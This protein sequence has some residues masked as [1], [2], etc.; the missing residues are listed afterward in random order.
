MINIKQS[1]GNCLECPSSR[2]NSILPFSNNPGNII[3]TQV[4][5]LISKPLTDDIIKNNFFSNNQYKKFFDLIK[6]YNLDQLNYMISSISL[7]QITVS[8]DD[9]ANID[10]IYK[11]CLNNTKH[12]IDTINP[13]IIVTFG[14]N[15]LK[16]L[17]NT[18]EKNILNIKNKKLKYK[19]SKIIP[20]NDIEDI[21]NNTKHSL[22]NFEECLQKLSSEFNIANDIKNNNDVYMK[23][24]GDSLYYYNID[25]KFY[26][27]EYRLIDVQY[28][29]KTN[30]VLYIFRD[31][32]NKKIYYRHNDDYYF[33][34]SKNNIT[35]KIIHDDNIKTY[36]IKW[37]D[38]YNI[39][40]DET[41]ESDVKINI[42][43]AIDY[44]LKNKGDCS[45]N[46]I[47]N[48]FFDIELDMKQ[49]ESFPNI[50]DAK[51]PINMI[52]VSYNNKNTVYIL[53]N[54]TQE[55]NKSNPE[56]E[57]KIFKKEKLLLM[58]FIKDFRNA[59]PDTISGWNT[60]SFD[61]PYLF[62]RL[63]RLNIDPNKLSPFGVFNVDMKWKNVT[64]AGV[65]CID[66]LEIYKLFEFGKKSSYSLNN[67]ASYE[68]GTTKLELE[69]SISKMY[70]TNINKLIDYNI[71]D[72][73][74]LVQ[75]ENKIG[76][77]NLVHEIR[78][79]C[80][81]SIA[82]I[83]S[84][85]GQVDPLM[86]SFM[87]KKNCVV[88]NAIRTGKE[89]LVGAYVKE[90]KPGIYKWI[91]DFD[92]TSLYPSIIRTY[93]IGVNTFIF[94]FVDSQLGYDLTYDRDNL[95][96][97]I[98]I[99]YDPNYENVEKIITKENL[100][101]MIDETKLL[102]TINGCF[103]LNHNNEISE[104]S[105][106]LN[107]LMDSRKIYKKKKFDA[108]VAKDDLMTR[109]YDTR[110]LVYKVLANSFYGVIANENFRFFN[111]Y[112][113][114]AITASGQEAIKT[115]VLSAHNKIESMYH[116]T[117]YEPFEK[118]SK[119]EMY[120]D[121]LSNSRHTDNVITSDTDSIF[122]CFEKFSDITMDNIRKYCDEIQSFLNENIIV[123]LL[124]KHNHENIN[125]N[126]LNM[127]NEL[128][129]KKGL[130][131]SKKHY[132][133]H[134]IEQE[135]KQ[136]N[137]IVHVG[138]DTKRSDV[139]EKTKELLNEIIDMIFQDDNITIN[140]IVKF[141]NMKEYEFINLLKNGEKSLSKSI[142]FTKSIDKYKRT[143]PQHINAMMNWNI[144]EYESFQVGDRGNLF[145]IN[146]IDNMKA[147]KKVIDTY[148]S[149][150]LKTGRKLDVIAVPESVNKLPS[151]YIVNIKEMM[152]VNFHDRYNILLKPI[153]QVKSQ[154][155]NL[156]TF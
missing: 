145:I 103:Y 141:I 44:G 48:W 136:V 111:I 40:L 23:Y 2:N 10:K 152:R 81:S 120:S 31:K 140:K 148:H 94:R 153:L 63:Q 147:P 144:L 52:S 11:C 80:S 150:F 138:I 50:E 27:D 121:T 102:W 143:I 15:V 130:F 146:G 117:N 61:L 32:N 3:D 155:N 132:V 110:Q 25:E 88:K 108:K 97:E 33:Y 56:Y 78:R 83:M 30:E 101:K 106:I 66:Q 142:S 67:I 68:L 89:K 133:I 100:F 62:F 35:K 41:Y 26:T 42:K 134:V 36:M 6:L 55:I 149:H 114:G 125:Y 99:I 43:H 104:L 24:I 28:L 112:S 131:V 47:N 123:D 122:C 60:N 18:K 70:Y 69:E 113:A 16:Y 9:E 38:R 90:P 151:Y 1:N 22:K 19:Q 75:L 65:A 91:V 74:L 34:K 86:I 14:I 107:Y 57:Y 127:K 129:C 37:R 12:L 76:Q 109:V 54:D 92:F 7:C 5:F 79:V 128:I 82:S 21:F 119:K 85:F 93:N 39:D 116:N 17:I 95:P 115:C 4:L 124:K 96:D 105:E 59:D 77:I 53:D 139:S 137:D 58:E 98:P 72:T 156:L 46:F 51:F 126:F 13:K 73:D 8:E 84:T 20:L 64:I 154:K 71:K 135:G 29:Y 45:A 118:I 87:K 49:T